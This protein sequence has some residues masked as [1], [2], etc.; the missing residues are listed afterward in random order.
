[1][2]DMFD[3]QHRE[4]YSQAL[5]ALDNASVDY[6]LGGAFAVYYYRG[7]WRDT[8]DIDIYILPQDLDDAKDALENAGFNDLG[9]QAGGDIAWIYH[10]GRDS[11]IVDAIFR[12][13]NLSN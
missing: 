13:A 8:H 9:E 7:W 12:F 4:M 11:L 10:A 6:M 5:T 2:K 3:V 1:M